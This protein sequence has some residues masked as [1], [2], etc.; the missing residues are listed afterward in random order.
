VTGKRWA[1][2]LLAIPYLFTLAMSTFH[3]AELYEL[4]DTG[5]KLPWSL[6]YGF[7]ASL[8]LTA[9]GL[10]LVSNVVKPRI[11]WA[12]HGATLSLLLVW[13][14]NLYQMAQSSVPLFVVI[15]ASFFSPMTLILGKVIGELLEAKEVV[16]RE[17]R[18]SPALISKKWQRSDPPKPDPYAIPLDKALEIMGGNPFQ[19]I[20]SKERSVS[21]LEYMQEKGAAMIAPVTAKQ[22]A[23]HIKVS[24]QT[25]RRE[26]DKLKKSGEVQSNTN[27]YWL[28]GPRGESA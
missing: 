25:V 24:T 16:V 28:A 19:P 9:F 1:A 2:I 14:G 11:T 8:E 13:A 3:L 12:M 5:H 21:L 18:L 20:P 27:G 22:L 23:E 10:S 17:K 4:F 6:S 7:A 15:G 26:M